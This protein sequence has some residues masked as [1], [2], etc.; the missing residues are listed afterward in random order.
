MGALVE[1]PF[2]AGGEMDFLGLLGDDVVLLLLLLFVCWRCWMAEEFTNGELGQLALSYPFATGVDARGGATASCCCC[3]ENMAL[4]LLLP[5]NKYVESLKG[6]MGDV[7]DGSGECGEPD[8]EV[9]EGSN[10][11]C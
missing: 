4:L 1:L 8:D 7:I 2:G 10:W 9:G 5:L 11:C 6:C 3:S